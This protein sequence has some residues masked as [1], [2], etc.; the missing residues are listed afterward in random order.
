LGVVDLDDAVYIPQNNFPLAIVETARSN[1][2]AANI[3]VPVGPKRTKQTAGIKKLLP[4]LR[5]SKSL[6]GAQ[7]K[8]DNR[9][10]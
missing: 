4:D 1:F 3:R 2:L 5:R 6:I 10:Q 8:D 7:G 9:Q